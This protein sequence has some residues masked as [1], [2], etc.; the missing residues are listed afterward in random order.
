M[1]ACVFQISRSVYW[2]S[3]M[4]GLRCLCFLWMKKRARRDV[5]CNGH[6]QRC[7]DRSVILQVTVVTSYRH[8]LLCALPRSNRGII[9]LLI[10]KWKYANKGDHSDNGGEIR[11]I[12][13]SNG[14]KSLLM[15][16]IV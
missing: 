8:S 15:K 11:K 9:M 10:E 2:I 14:K 16:K 1:G 3:E 12:K 6:G 4:V 5:C 7:D 13:R